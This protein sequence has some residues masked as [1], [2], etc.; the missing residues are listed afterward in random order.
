MKTMGGF[1]HV[2]EDMDKI[3]NHGDLGLL[4]IGNR[5]APSTSFQ[6]LMEQSSLSA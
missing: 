2:F 3:D 5:L 1:P 6:R 4:L